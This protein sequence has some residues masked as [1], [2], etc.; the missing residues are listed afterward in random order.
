ML[1]N[2][3]KPKAGILNISYKEKKDDNNKM[4]AERRAHVTPKFISIVPGISEIPDS[5]W[6]RIKDDSLIVDYR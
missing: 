1:V 2:Y 5:K 4:S 3:K 6:N